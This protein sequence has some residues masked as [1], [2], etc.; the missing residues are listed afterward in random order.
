MTLVVEHLIELTQ[1]PNILRNLICPPKPVKPVDYSRQIE[2][3]IHRTNEHK[4]IE[5]AYLQLII[6]IVRLRAE[7]RFIWHFPKCQ[8]CKANLII[9][10]E[11]YCGCHTFWYL[12]LE[13]SEYLEEQYLD[14]PKLE[15]YRLGNYWEQAK[16]CEKHGNTD[17]PGENTYQFILDRANWAYKI[18][19]NQIH[20]ARQMLR[21]VKAWDFSEAQHQEYERLYDQLGT[22]QII[23]PW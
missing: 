15:N 3:L 8:M 5:I 21:L 19:G 6:E 23:I 14:I 1:R 7:A 20:S 4:W 2:K 12:S 13:N 17:V 22:W 18:Y 9:D 16:W 11:R 10:V